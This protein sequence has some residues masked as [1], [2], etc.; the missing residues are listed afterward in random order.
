MLQPVKGMTIPQV[1]AVFSSTRKCGN[2][3]D[4]NNWGA[5]GLDAREIGRVREIGA[6]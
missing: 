3:G 5:L 2:A 4:V 1:D 6:I